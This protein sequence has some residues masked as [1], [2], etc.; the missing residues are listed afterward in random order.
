MNF[1][2]VDQIN[3]G[4]TTFR[5]SNKSNET[6]F[7]IL[8]KLSDGVGIEKYQKEFLSPFKKAY[9]YFIEGDIITG[10]KQ[11]KDLPA[12]STK[13]EICGAVTL[14]SSK[15]TSETTLSLQHLLF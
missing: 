12:W 6:H 11:F 2:M 9:N 13:M 15:K 7:F 5:Y 8:E 10:N 1:K 14:T 4:W 3:S